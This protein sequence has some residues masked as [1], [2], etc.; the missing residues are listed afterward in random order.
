VTV[1]LGA[2]EF[3]ID[4]DAPDVFEVQVQLTKAAPSESAVPVPDPTAVAVK[5]TPT[6]LLAAP[7]VVKFVVP[8]VTI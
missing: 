5:T 3:V 8:T 1:A 4:A 2:L 7:I 6:V